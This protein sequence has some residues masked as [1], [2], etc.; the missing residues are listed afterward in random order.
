LGEMFDQ[1][2][3]PGALP[4]SLTNLCFRGQPPVQSN[5]IKKKK[6]KKFIYVLQTRCS[7]GSSTRPD[8]QHACSQPQT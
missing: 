5:K 2:I 7:G 6:I 8:C 3:L 1:P 4:A